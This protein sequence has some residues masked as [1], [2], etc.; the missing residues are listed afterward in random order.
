MAVGV[1]GEDKARYQKGL[2]VYRR[3]VQE[4]FKWGRGYAPGRILGEA[5]ETLRDIY[6]TLFGLGSLVQVSGW[7]R[8]GRGGWA[9][10]RGGAMR[11]RHRGSATAWVAA[12]AGLRLA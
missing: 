1:L 7:A 4:Y 8:G 2:A 12:G 9:G 3:T 11:E 10:E 6:H 5:T